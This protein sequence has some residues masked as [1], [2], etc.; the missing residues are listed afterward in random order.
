MFWLED[1]DSNSRFFHASTSVRKKLNH[2]DYLKTEVGD[3]VTDEQGMCDVVKDYFTN[4]F[5]GSNTVT[6]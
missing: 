1:G 4:I 3:I 2:V 5:T 6:N